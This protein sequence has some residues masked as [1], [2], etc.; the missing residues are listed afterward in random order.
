MTAAV[1]RPGDTIVHQEFWRGRLWAARPLTVVEDS[2]D[3]LVL[4]IPEGT[5]SPGPL[6]FY[7]GRATGPRPG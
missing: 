7:R 3:R 2:G 1:W 6:T 5:G 4:W